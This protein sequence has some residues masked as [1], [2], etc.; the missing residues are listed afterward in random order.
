[1]SGFFHYRQQNVGLKIVLPGMNS[2][3]SRE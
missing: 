1:M 2:Y 3:V